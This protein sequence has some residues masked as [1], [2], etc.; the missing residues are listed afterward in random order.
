MASTTSPSLLLRIRDPNDQ[1]AWSLFFDLYEPIVRSYSFQKRI[2]PADMDD[3]VQDV[4][5]SVAK[6]IRSF[7]YDPKKGRFR[8][9]FGTVTA[10]RI[11][12]FLGKQNR[13][14]EKTPQREI[15]NSD[16]YVDPD[17]DWITIFSERVFWSACNR[18]RNNF[19]ETTWACFEATWV[20][21]E[22]ANEVAD[23][24][25]VPVHSVYVNKSRVVK[26]LESEIRLLA[27][28]MPISQGDIS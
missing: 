9:W 2:Q 1:D 22:S 28:D 5:S 24:L 14:R 10:N 23:Q 16:E 11:K 6:A 18:I 12:T 13:Q 25:N 4:M 27:D 26:R 7:E 21:N 15:V 19:N 8:A 20:R 3:I 17:T